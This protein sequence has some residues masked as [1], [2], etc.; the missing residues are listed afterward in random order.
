MKYSLNRIF[1][2]WKA[3]SFLPRLFP[4]VRSPRAM[5][6][7]RSTIREASFAAGWRGFWVIWSMRIASVE[8]IV[9]AVLTS[10]SSDIPWAEEYADEICLENRGKR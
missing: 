3:A 10:G 6:N 5:L 4:V 9:A 8:R 1:A 7:A 2:R